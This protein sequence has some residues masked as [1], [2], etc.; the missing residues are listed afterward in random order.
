M[1]LACMVGS[2]LVGASAWAIGSGH[3]WIGFLPTWAA[4]ILGV[5]MA[6]GPLFF[7]PD[8][9]IVDP[10]SGAVAKMGGPTIRGLPLIVWVVPLLLSVGLGWFSNP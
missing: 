4:L 10:R 2:I 1:I 6:G 9:R 7:L 3:G 5:V 8:E